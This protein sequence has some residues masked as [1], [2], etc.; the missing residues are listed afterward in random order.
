LL[1]FGKSMRVSAIRPS[2]CARF[3]RSE[4]VSRA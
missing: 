1:R 2:L 4:T 3:G